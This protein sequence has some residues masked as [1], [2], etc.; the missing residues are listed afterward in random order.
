MLHI[1][2]SDEHFIDPE[3]DDLGRDRVGFK[4]TMSPQA[5][6]DANHGCWVLGARANTEQYYVATYGGIVRQAVEIEG[7]TRGTLRPERSIL[8]GRI[9]EPGH[10]VYDE[11]VGKESPVQGVRNPVT[12]FDSHLEGRLCECGC[13][14]PTAGGP[15]LPGHDQTAL[16]ARVKQIGTVSEFIRWFDSLAAGLQ[17]S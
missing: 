5:L 1:T 3:K 14:A 11:Y 9:L 13:E 2:M 15:F 17:K 8:H 16:H 4:A 6:Y 7:I 10:P 12:Y